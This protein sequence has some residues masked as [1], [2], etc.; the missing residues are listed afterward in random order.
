MTC[1]PQDWLNCVPREVQKTPCKCQAQAMW[2]LSALRLTLLE[3][4]KV[5][6]RHGMKFLEVCEVLLL[7]H[8]WKHTHGGMVCH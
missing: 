8:Q 4:A 2:P 7:L 3:M 1:P 6:M 5:L